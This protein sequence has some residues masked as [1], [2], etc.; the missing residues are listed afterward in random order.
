MLKVIK[1]DEM[2]AWESRPFTVS[3]WA[4]DFVK[5]LADRP[6]IVRILLRFIFGKY[7]Y[8]EFIGIVDA[9]NAAGIYVNYELNHM[10]YH[11]GKVRSDFLEGARRY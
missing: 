2:E 10:N 11:Q 6:K 9:L 5:A 7:A 8:R 3:A 1:S 4:E